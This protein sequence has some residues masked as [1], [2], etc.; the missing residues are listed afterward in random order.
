MAESVIR[1]WWARL[2]GRL[3]PAPCPFSDSWI[4]E[5]PVRA[6][7][8]GAK[9]IL[10]LFGLR[11][12]ERVLEIGPGI[13]YYSLEAARMIGPTGLLVCLD[14]QREMLE[15]VRRKAAGLAASSILFVR[16]DA[17]RLPFRAG[18]FDRTILI[19]VLGELPDRPRALAGVGRVLRPGGR[20]SVSEQFPDP[21]FI[22]LGALR[23]ELRA[24]GFVE[25][26]ARGILV[27]A[28]TW[29]APAVGPCGS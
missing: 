12:G 19:T 24:I 13:G 25:E 17:L 4:L 2:R 29:C 27:H 3:K 5:I 15:T 7:R 11:P 22:T 16:A 20:L 9:R 10:G 18:A 1:S 14:I 21:D 26:A 6:L 8:A 23:R 28:S